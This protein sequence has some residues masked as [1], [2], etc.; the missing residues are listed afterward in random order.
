MFGYSLLI[1]E[2][3]RVY[4][5]NSLTI[6]FSRLFQNKYLITQRLHY[7]VLILTYDVILRCH[8]F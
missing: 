8:T 2:K 3:N 5:F 4:Y 6:N 1:K 7:T